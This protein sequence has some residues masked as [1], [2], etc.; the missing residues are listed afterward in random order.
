MTFA[1]EWH[2]HLTMRHRITI[3]LVMSAIGFI[4][5][6]VTHL[7]VYYKL[8]EFSTAPFVDKVIF[9]LGER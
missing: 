6:Y 2:K 8:F 1:H 5:W 7:E 3:A 9:G 4:A